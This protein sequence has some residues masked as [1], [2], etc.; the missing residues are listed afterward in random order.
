MEKLLFINACMRGRDLS[1][2][3][4]LCK[5]FIDNYCKTRPTAVL[6]EVDLTVNKLP[7]YDLEVL[8]RRDSLIDSG[9]LQDEMFRYAKQFAEANKIIV[10]APYWDLSFPAALK[11]YVEH[12]SVRNISFRNVA[13]GVAGM[14]LAEKLIYITTAGGYISGADFGADYFRGLC[15]FFGIK[16]FERIYAEGLDI[17]TNEPEAIMAAAEKKAIQASGRF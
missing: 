1:R 10:G 16:H 7:C 11:V 14:C 6:H 8:K 9:N 12:V 13:D 2:T 17:E 15:K 3:Y 5:V 4:R